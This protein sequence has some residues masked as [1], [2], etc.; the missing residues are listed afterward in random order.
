MESSGKASRLGAIS[1]ILTI[2]VVVLWCI[3][4]IIFAATTE[5]GL[6]FGAD[7][8]TIGYAVVLGGGLVMGVL[9]ILLTLSGIITGGLALRDKDSK[10]FQTWSCHCRAGA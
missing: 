2:L 1:F 10:R 8:E 9:T 7:S 4:L 3:Y 5:G 6:N